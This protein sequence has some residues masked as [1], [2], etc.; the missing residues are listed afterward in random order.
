MILRC[1]MGW[2]RW[3]WRWG[4]LAR[5]RLRVRQQGRDPRLVRFP[6]RSAPSVGLPVAAAIRARLRGDDESD[7][8]QSHPARAPYEN[9]ADFERI[10]QGQQD[11]GLASEPEAALRLPETIDRNAAVRQH[12]RRGSAATAAD[13]VSDDRRLAARRRAAPHRSSGAFGR[14]RPHRRRQSGV[15]RTSRFRRSHI[16][17]CDT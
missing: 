14:A 11:A 3:R 13:A 15:G 5:A 12:R 6:A 4:T 17:P 1:W 9:P 10:M 8:A 7:R 2:R 16:L